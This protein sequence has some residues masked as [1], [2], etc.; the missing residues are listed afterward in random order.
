VSPGITTLLQL[1]QEVRGP[2][3]IGCDTPLARTGKVGRPRTLLCGDHQ[4]NLT[5]YRLRRSKVRE[6]AELNVSLD[7]ALKRALTA[8][9]RAQNTL[10]SR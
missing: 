10:S 8:V 5:Y 6:L 4:C 7:V 9:R 1:E 3:C 2:A